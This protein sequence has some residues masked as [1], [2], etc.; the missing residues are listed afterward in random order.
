MVER[1]EGLGFALETRDAL[2]IRREGLG[3]DLDGHLAAEGR[4]GGAVDLPHPA[5]ADPGGD[6]VD[7]KPGT[8]GQGQWGGEIIPT[9]RFGPSTGLGI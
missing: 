5:F 8:W 9:S 2:G 7:A 4:V 6:F 3:K 1:R